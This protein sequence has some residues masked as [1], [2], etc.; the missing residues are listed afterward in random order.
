MLPQQ[1][2][3]ELDEGALLIE[4]A[5]ASEEEPQW[6]ESEPSAAALLA[7]LQHTIHDRPDPVMET[8]YVFS[9]SYQSLARLL[10]SQSSERSLQDLLLIEDADVAVS[11]KTAAVSSDLPRLEQF[12][13]ALNNP[14][15]EFRT[16]EGLAEDLDVSPE[17]VES[18]LD[19]YPELVRWLPATDSEGR[20]LLVSARRPMTWKERLLRLGAYAGKRS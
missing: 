14:K 15:W 19:D 6:R 1:P 3:E 2:F 16:I 10:R 18:I 9:K 20:R 11:P 4:A 7:A 12:I 17:A 5:F 13:E 8:R